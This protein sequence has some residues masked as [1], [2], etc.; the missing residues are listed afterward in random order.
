MTESHHL[1]LIAEHSF[2]TY[3]LAWEKKQAGLD[4]QQFVL[5]RLLT[6]T[7]LEVDRVK[8]QSGFSSEGER[9]QAFID[10]GHGSLATWFIHAKTLRHVGEEP[11]R[12]LLKHTGPPT[13]AVS[14]QC[15]IKEVE[16]LQFL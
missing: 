2:R 9:V 6:G 16:S 3:V 13:P 11:P 1:H 8:T 14:S 4:W 15:E 12:L 7:A 10:R 5:S